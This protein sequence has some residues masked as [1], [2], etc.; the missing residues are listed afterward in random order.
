MKICICSDSHG[1][2]F[3]LQRLLEREAPDY[4][5]FLGDGLRDWERVKLPPLLPFAAVRGNCDPLC[6]E[7]E[8]RCFILCGK[9]ILL[10]HGHR[11]GVKTGLLPLEA[12][13]VE[14]GLDLIF[15]GHTHR[16]AAERF[17]ACQ[18]VCPGS[19]SVGEERYAILNLSPDAPAQVDLRRL[20]ER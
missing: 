20:E 16:P 8:E 7:P 17:G 18:I 12:E 19:M 13:A 10:T 14:Q 1:N 3:G 4:L 2:A 11:R 9:R 5:W 6:E 15:Y